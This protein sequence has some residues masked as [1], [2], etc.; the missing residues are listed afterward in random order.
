MVKTFALAVVLLS[1]LAAGCGSPAP[2]AESIP[3][4]AP[5]R[6]KDGEVVRTPKS[7]PAGPGTTPIEIGTHCG[8]GSTPIDYDGTFWLPLHVLPEP[9]PGLTDPFDRGEIRLTGPNSATYSSR[10]GATLLLVRAAPGPH[11]FRLCR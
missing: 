3:A 11:V 5:L 4:V 10:N 1:A 2:T 8:V 7:G 9:V 6:A